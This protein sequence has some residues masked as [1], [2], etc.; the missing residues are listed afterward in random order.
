[1]LLYILYIHLKTLKFINCNIIPYSYFPHVMLFYIHYMHLKILKFIN[2]IINC[3]IVPYLYFPHIMLLIIMYIHLKLWYVFTVLQAVISS[4]IYI[5][6][7]I[8]N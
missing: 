3:N 1:M 5:S 8:C 4:Q 7:K 2:C 6:L